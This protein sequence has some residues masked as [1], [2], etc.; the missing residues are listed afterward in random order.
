MSNKRKKPKL[1]SFVDE[2]KPN[3]NTNTGRGN[4]E[5]S[6][7]GGRNNFKHK[8]PKVTAT[9]K[10]LTA[11]IGGAKMENK[12]TLISNLIKRSNLNDQFG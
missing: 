1:S 9:K 10:P 12:I 4:P 11:I 8:K 6:G 3:T 7:A 5:Q 2:S